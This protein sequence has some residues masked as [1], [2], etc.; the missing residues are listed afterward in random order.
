MSSLAEL[1]VQP[2]YIKKSKG[3]LL[4]LFFTDLMKQSCDRD[5][6]FS[7]YLDFNLVSKHTLKLSNLVKASRI[8]LYLRGLTTS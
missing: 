8:W 2:F 6:L 3:S 1:E 4:L 7:N 5:T